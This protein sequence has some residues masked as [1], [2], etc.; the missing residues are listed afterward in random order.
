MNGKRNIIFLSILLTIPLVLFSQQI[1]ETTPFDLELKNKSSKYTHEVHFYKAQTFFFERTWDSTLVYTMKQ[2]SS[3]KNNTELIDYCHFLRG[4]S[5]KYKKL[6]KEAEKEFSNVSSNF[7]FSPHIKMILG[8]IALEQQDFQKAI[9]YF[10]Q[11]ETYT[12]DQLLGLE[13]SNIDHNLGICYLHLEQYGLAETYLLESVTLYEQQKDTIELIRAYGNIANLYYNQYKDKQAIPYFETAY[14]LSEKTKHYNSKMNATYNMYIVE[15][16]R[17]NPDAAYSYIEKYDVLKDTFNDQNQVW[18]L[19]KQEEKFAVQ[20]K[21]KEVSL[22]EAENKVK[23]AQKDGLLYSAIILLI[24]LGTSFYFYRE[25]VRTNK[26]IVTQ[27]ENLNELNATKDKLFSIVSHDLRSSVQALKTSNKTLS[28]TL[29]AKDF[30]KVNTLLQTN[31]GIVN[32]AYNLLDNLLNWAL[33]QTKQSYF[34]IAPQRLSFIVEHVAHNYQALFLEKNIHF[35]NTISK[36]DKVFADQESLK[37][38]LRNILDNAIK[39]SSTNGSIKVYTQHTQEGYCDLI[40]EDTG[41]GMSEATRQN[42]LQENI[43][44]SE[45]EHKDIIGSGLGLQLCKSMIQKNNGKF[46]IESVLGKG[47]KMIVSLSETPS[48]G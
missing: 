19:A 5:F 22:L 26:V 29:E 31:S 21:Q 23:E 38:I 12:T 20:Q 24:L 3:S 2:L 14:Q 46:F 13:K 41:M 37:I 35:E 10:K 44:T 25:K 7:E 28:N 8:E 9:H 1:I 30:D 32:G 39:F 34:E 17:N 48:H 27:K 33:L 36:N 47:T 16:N 15:K 18:K 40:I 43:V 4:F 11:I 42:L 6:F 45:K